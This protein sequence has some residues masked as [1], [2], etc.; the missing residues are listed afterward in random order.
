[1]DSDSTCLQRV[2]WREGAENCPPPAALEGDVNPAPKQGGIRSGRGRST[3]RGVRQRTYLDNPGF[4]DHP[5]RKK[6]QVFRGT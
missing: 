6:S 3:L 1:M 4:D 2:G 5:P